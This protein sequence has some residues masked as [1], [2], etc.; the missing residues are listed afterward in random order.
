MDNL[1]SNSILLPCAFCQYIVQTSLVH[2]AQPN[3]LYLQ[4]TPFTC[5]AHIP[6]LYKALYCT[7]LYTHQYIDYSVFL[8]HFILF[9]WYQSHSSDSLV[10]VDISGVLPL[11]ST[12]SSRHCQKRATAVTPTVPATLG[13]QRSAHSTAKEKAQKDR[14]A[15]PEQNPTKNGQKLHHTHLHALLEVSASRAR[16]VGTCHAPYA[17]PT[18][19]STLTHM[20]HAPHVPVVLLFLPRKPQVTSHCHVSTCHPLTVD[21]NR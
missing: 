20:P 21:S 19:Q 8:S 3:I 2:W 15:N 9:T 17:P 12:S 6:S 13:Y 4:F 7:L 5:T 18:H 11:P 16:A 10:P 1:T 14:I